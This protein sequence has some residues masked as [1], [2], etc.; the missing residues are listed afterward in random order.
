MISRRSSTSV[1]SSGIVLAPMTSRD[2]TNSSLIRS[3]E[4]V[5]AKAL[6]SV[7]AA[8]R[9]DHGLTDRQAISCFRQASGTGR[10]G[11]RGGLMP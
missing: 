1:G 6:E 10:F 7:L 9:K 4:L 5:L 8:H 2:G 3:A 11:T